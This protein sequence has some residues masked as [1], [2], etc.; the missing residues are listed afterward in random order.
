MNDGEGLIMREETEMMVEINKLR[1]AAAMMTP[2]TTPTPSATLTIAMRTPT[3][4]SAM[5][6]P[7][8]L[9]SSPQNEVRFIQFESSPKKIESPSTPGTLQNVKHEH[10][11]YWISDSSEEEEDDEKDGDYKPVWRKRK[12]G[13]TPCRK[14]SKRLYIKQENS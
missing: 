3:L 1:G 7:S 6:H 10:D 4:V 9:S 5:I 13:P 2:G 11:L 8:A 12:K 14:A